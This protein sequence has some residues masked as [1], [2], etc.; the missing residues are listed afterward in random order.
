M[1]AFDVRTGRQRW[2]FHTVPQ[3]GESGHDTWPGD[4]WQ[5]RTGVNVWT[6]MSVDEARA[7]SSCRGLGVL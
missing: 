4:A 7:W 6:S 1:R 3:P 5:R 2:R